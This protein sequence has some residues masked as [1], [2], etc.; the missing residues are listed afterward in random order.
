MITRRTFGRGLLAAGGIAAVGAGGGG[1][2]SRAR[3]ATLGDD[4]LY[5]Q[6]WFV[7]S[8]LE[9][10]DDIAEAQ[11]AGKHFVVMFEQAGCPFCRKTHEVNLQR[12]D[13]LPYLKE[14]F[15]ILQL[16]L[17]GAREVVDFDGEAM[18]ERALG[19]RWLVNF[20]P[21]ILFFPMQADTVIGQPGRQG[22][23]A[24]IQGYLPP[25]YFYHFFE[26]VRSGAHETQGFQRYANDRVNQLREQGTDPDA[27]RLG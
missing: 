21:T 24:R 17:F 6:D 23:L 16:D 7:E 15:A 22:E 10:S 25:F 1:G 20:T 13:Y 26:W 11:D 2:A 18:E 5:K 14:N 12:A 4:G 9:L 8:F 27:W 19:R 3:A